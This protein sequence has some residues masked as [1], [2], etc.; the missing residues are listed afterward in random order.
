VTITQSFIDGEPVASA[1]HYDNLD[2][3]TGRSLGAVA[4]GGDREVD[5]AVTAARTASPRWRDT[6]L[7]IGRHC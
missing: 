5:R 3:A 6:P 2:P 1:E 4:R 7:P